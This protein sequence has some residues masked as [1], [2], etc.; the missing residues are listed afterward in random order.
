MVLIDEE[1]AAARAAEA[2]RFACYRP[3]L[4]R[5]GPRAVAEMRGVRY[6]R[7]GL[8]FRRDYQ[9]AVEA[10]DDVAQWLGYG[11]W[12]VYYDAWRTDPAAMRRRLEA[13]Q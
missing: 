11:D 12:V 1:K 4:G 8:P 6:T 3:V 5:R 9:K 13:A 7:K 10:A 2:P